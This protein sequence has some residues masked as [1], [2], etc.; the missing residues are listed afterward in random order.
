MPSRTPPSATLRAAVSEE[1]VLLLG[2]RLLALDAIGGRG[3]S[4]EPL[5]PATE[6]RLRSELAIEVDRFL[7]WLDSRSTSDAVS[8]LHREAEEVRRRHLDRLRR[9]A[10]LEPAQLRAVEA[11]TAAMVGELLHGPSREL[12]RGGADAAAVRR[13]FG[14]EP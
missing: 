9:R 2:E 5:A 12:G 10:G 4:F 1:A 8:L 6:R 13:I 11:A 7:A 14:V 3:A